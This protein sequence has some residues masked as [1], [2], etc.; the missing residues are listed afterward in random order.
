MKSLWLENSLITGPYL[1]LVINE[2][3]FHK[4]MNHCKI[5]IKDRGNW[6]PNDHSDATCYTLENPDGKM[7]CIVAIRVK[8]KQDPNEIIGLLIHESVHVWQQFCER[9]GESNPSSEFEAYSIQ[10]ISQSLIV[11]YSELT[12]KK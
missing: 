9:I 1:A 10:A 7:C 8:K 3:Q 2:K 11:A 12:A 4:A 6:I 5:P